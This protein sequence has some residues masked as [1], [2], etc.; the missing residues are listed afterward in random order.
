[1]KEL[2]Q[3]VPKD[4]EGHHDLFR[5]FLCTRWLDLGQLLFALDRTG[6]VDTALQRVRHLTTGSR[7]FWTEFATAQSI[8]YS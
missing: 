6:R 8:G 1:M 4:A 7:D 3:T 5:F 2:A